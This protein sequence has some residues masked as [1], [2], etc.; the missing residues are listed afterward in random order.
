[1]LVG[2]RPGSLLVP[3]GCVVGRWMPGRLFVDGND[4]RVPGC[5]KLPGR[6]GVGFKPP[7]GRETSGRDMFGRVKFGWLGC[8]RPTVPG[9]KLGR[10][11]GAGRLAAEGR[12]AGAGRLP[13]RL[14]VLPRE[15]LGRAPPAGRAPPRPFRPSAAAAG[16]WPTTSKTATTSFSIARV[17]RKTAKEKS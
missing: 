11:V 2:G 1:M 15:I 3:P 5:G 7:L 14:G 8:G 4:G 12:L 10:L 9:P 17:M 16:T 13:P 6:F